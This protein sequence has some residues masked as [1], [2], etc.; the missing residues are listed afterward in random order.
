M[1]PGTARTI[2]LLNLALSLALSILV[3]LRADTPNWSPVNWGVFFLALTVFLGGPIALFLEW[4]VTRGWSQ[5]N[6]YTVERMQIDEPV[7]PHGRR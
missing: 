6:P 4:R 7:S 5:P 2:L 3:G 1:T